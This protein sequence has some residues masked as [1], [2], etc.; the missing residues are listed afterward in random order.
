[1]PAERIVS[2]VGCGDALLTGFLAGIY[3]N[4]E[5]P[6][7]LRQAVAAA[8]ATATNL[9]ASFTREQFAEFLPTARVDSLDG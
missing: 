6:D 7:S 5:L 3:S 1:V 8:G 2:T 4:L 9:T